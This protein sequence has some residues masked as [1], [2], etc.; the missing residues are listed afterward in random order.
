MS[1]RGTVG[2][3]SAIL[4]LACLVA[5]GCGSSANDHGVTLRFWALGREGE[6]VQELVRDFE[7]ENPD[8][9]V[10][11]QQI[12]WGAA[13]EKLLTAYVGGATPDLGQIGNTWISEFATLRAIEPL[14]ARLGGGVDSSRFFSGIW[15]TNVLDGHT[16]GVPWY[17]DTR[18][19]F[20]RT[21]VLARAGYHTM[22]TTW[23]EWR[24]AMEAVKRTVG[25]D[26]YAIFLPTNEFMQAM[27]FGMQNGSP[28]LADHDTRGAFQDSTFRRAFAFYLDCSARGSHRRW[29]TTTSR[30][31]T[32]SS[33]A[34]RSRCT[35]PVLGISVS[36]AAVCPSRCNRRG[37]RRRCRDRAARV[38][39][40]DR[41]RLE[42]W[43][44]SA[45]R[46]IRTK[47]GG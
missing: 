22:P 29:A 16:Y 28:M 35:S 4:A 43:C 20:Y 41:R 6:V 3:A 5:A 26:R 17:V 13:H 18:V 36:S 42:L 21:D 33:S 25:K 11:V 46:S 9:R 40:L 47:R 1:A 24:T 39:H 37:A 8:I 34:A 38:R 2:L 31:S 12:P 30:T 32:R 45:A 10:Q 27:V 19:V 14:D 44:C 23:A 15:D 7:R